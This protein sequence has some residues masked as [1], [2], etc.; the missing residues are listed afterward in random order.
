M[1]STGTTS[2][3]A[4]MRRSPTAT[5]STP[6]VS[7]VSW[8]YRWA[9]V[10][11]RSSRA[12]RS[13]WAR[14]AAQD[15][16]AR[17]LRTI[18]LMTAPAR[19]SPTATAPATANSAMRSIPKRRRR[20]LATVDQSEYSAPAT[21]TAIHTPSPALPRPRRCN[22]PP[23]NNPTNARTNRPSEASGRAPRQWGTAL[24]TVPAT[25]TPFLTEGRTRHAVSA[26]S[27]PGA[28][29]IDPRLTHQGGEL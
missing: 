5:A 12:R 23:R 8:R 20:R 18:T 28:V 15:S 27:S 22:N 4:T 29:G 2:P 1:P 21:P 16:R 26:S 10:G 17:P 24:A 9:T 7:R 3:G 13:R 25:A 19:Y 6:T 11:A 14:P